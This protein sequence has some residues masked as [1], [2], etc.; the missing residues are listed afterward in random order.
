MAQTMKT[1][2]A[3]CVLSLASA[4]CSV[5]EPAVRTPNIVVIL[6]DDLGYGDLGC[7]GATKVNTPC[8]DTFAAQAVR[9]TDAHSASSVCTPSRYALLTGEYPFRK[10][11]W[12]PLSYSSPLCVDTMR[13]TLPS[14]LKSKG[15]TTACIGKWHLGFGTK[16]NPDWN[17]DLK[18]GP[19]ECGFDYFYGIPVVSSSPPFV[20]VE[21]HRV[22]GIDPADPIK[23]GG[24]SPSRVYPEKNVI[25]LSGGKAAHALYQ[26]E[27][28]GSMLAG[29]AVS[30]I[31]EQK[32]RP[33]FLY[34]AT[35]HIHHPF[36][37]GKRFQG[38][39]QCGVYGDYIQEFD[40]IVGEVL[41]SLDELRL[42]ENT[43]VIV[44][45][46]NGG[47]LNR[48]G[49]AAWM[50]GHRLNGN[51]L[52]FK[53]DAWEGGHRIPFIIRWPGKG[54]PGDTSSQLISLVDLPATFAALT[55]A[56]LTP[57]DAPDS[58]NVLRAFDGTAT[59]QIRDSLV[60]APNKKTNLAIRQG[61]W[62][63]IGAKGGGGWTESSPGDHLL[64]GPGALAFTGEQNS[65]IQGSKFKA[66]AP[67]AQLYDLATDPSQTT[68]VIRRHPE[69]AT[70]MKTLLDHIIADGQ[71]APRAK[72]NKM[73]CS[74]FKR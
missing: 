56:T 66:D 22:V 70:Q 69:V 3:L 62:V 57:G 17:A 31:R 54:S 7:Y 5:A 29:K 11:L 42:A 33:F 21:N 1:P 34:F 16:P 46:D 71:S 61:P 2:T 28:L 59:A 48:G 52:G 8:I 19:L 49:Q 35:P 10:N 32:D 27:Q 12:N 26:D 36:T 4:Y 18:P 24:T 6:A 23:Y 25:G 72:Q 55:G 65:D 74:L 64:G 53:F 73:P 51:L 39:S 44:T 58:V 9:F 37:P 41:R 63:Y 43:I 14:I 20:F 45:S 67:K 40:W 13:A 50:A 47:M 38:S 15:Y 68:N 30:W 60:L